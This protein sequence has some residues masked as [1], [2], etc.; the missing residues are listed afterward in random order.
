M[1]FYDFTEIFTNFDSLFGVWYGKR[2]IHE[3][4]EEIGSKIENILWGATRA[5][6]VAINS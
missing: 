5:W 2:K 6:W 1:K 3:Y 4:L